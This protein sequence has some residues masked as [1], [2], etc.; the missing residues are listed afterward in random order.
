M[1]LITFLGCIYMDGS[2]NRI[3][4]MIDDYRFDVTEYA[5]SHPGGRK[6]LEQY[7]NKDATKA[8]NEVRGHSD[9]YVLGL[10]DEFCIGKVDKKT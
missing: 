10:L 3:V 6:I 2:G 9:G 4:I 7:N 5:E 8:F 1:T